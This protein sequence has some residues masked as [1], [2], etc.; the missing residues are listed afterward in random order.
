MAAPLVLVTGS[1]DGIGRETAC[2]LAERGAR[3]I[4]HGRDPQRLEAA[5]KAVDARSGSWPVAQE[6]ADLASLETVRQLGA[7]L[8]DEFPRIDVLVNNAGVIM[9][10]RVLTPEGLETTFVVNHLA[11]LL[12][13]HLLLPALTESP[14]GRIVN[15]SS[16]VQMG[17]RLDWDNLQGE[18][19]FESRG[20]YALSKL[21]NVLFTTELA[22]RLRSTG[23]T[24]N[25]LQPGVVSTKLLRAGFGGHGSDSLAEGAA[26][27]VHLAL[28]PEVAQTTGAYFH[29][30]KPLRTNPLAGERAVTSR[31]YE[32][33]CQLVGIAP[34]P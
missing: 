31:F 2:I 25:A 1:S 27:S 17:A 30:S 22:R 33:S 23:I 18:K 29:R 11:P 16:G 4:L 19:H 14:Q 20:A 5:A 9:P 15:V 10:R 13:T 34:L 28:A 6:L 32:L 12:L 8:L 24:V 3:V 26:T 7:R 21:A